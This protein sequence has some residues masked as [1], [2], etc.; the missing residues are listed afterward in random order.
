MF[1]KNLEQQK[2]V[3]F[4]KWDK[5][6]QSSEVEVNPIKQTLNV[7]IEP[8]RFEK[9]HTRSIYPNG[10]D[11][12][13]KKDIGKFLK[14]FSLNGE[15]SII[16]EYDGRRFV[17]ANVDGLELPFYSSSQGTGGKNKGVWYPF[18]GFS[19][20]GWVMKDGFDKDGNWIYNR[21]AN[22]ELQEKIKTMAEQLSE[23]ISLPLNPTQFIENIE[24]YFTYKELDD[25]TDRK[26]I[27]NALGLPKDIDTKNINTNS[28]FDELERIMK[29]LLTREIKKS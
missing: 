22:K 18:Y 17:I 8:S 1:N 28:G 6:T 15:N 26:I 21:T 23:N 13:V 10:V 5:D 12:Y 19:E 11:L 25:K 14:P 29:F 9:W 3:I 2:K 7:H 20:S 16:Q 27:N 24:D 4:D